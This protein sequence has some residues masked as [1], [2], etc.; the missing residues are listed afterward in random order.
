MI[1]PEKFGELIAK[2][3]DESQVPLRERI[4]ALENQVRGLM[5]QPPVGVSYAGIAG[6][7]EQG[8]LYQQGSLVTKGGS[9]WLALT[10][11]TNVTPGASSPGQWRLIVKRGDA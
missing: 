3:I 9:L 4:A 7:Y 8:K 1:D 10:T 11:L 2:A 5:A 6:I